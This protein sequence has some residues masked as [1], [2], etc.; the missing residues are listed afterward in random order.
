MAVRIKRI[1]FD[2]ADPYRLAQF[3]SQVTGLSEDPG[4]GNAPDDQAPVLLSPDGSLALLFM[5]VPEPEHLKNRVHLDLVPLMSRRD[6]EVDQLL[7][8]GARM[9]DDQRGPDGGG[10]VVLS[11]PEGNEFCVERSDAERAPLAGQLGCAFDAVADLIGNIRADQWPAPTPCADWTVRQVVNHLIG[12]NRV[13]AALL[14]GEPPPPRPSEDHVEDDPV[15]AYRASAAV[16]QAAFSRPGVLERTY[17]GPLGTAT[18]AERLQIRLYDLL[19]H[20]WDLAQATG[21]PVVLPYDLAE[22]SLVFAQTQL[23]EQARPGRFGP[24]QIVARQAPAI[25]RLVAFLGRPVN[26]DTEPMAD[27]ANQGLVPARLRRGIVVRAR[28]D[29]CEIFRDGRLCTLR[30]ATQFPSPRTERVSPGHLVA[31]ASAPDD[32]EVVVWR[33]YDAVVLGEEAG[34]VRLWEPSHGE[35]LAQPRSMHQSSQPGSRA[36]LSAGLPGADWWVA[37]G[38]A[39][40]AEDADVELDEV[41]QFYTGRELWGILL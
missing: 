5:A 12:M 14:A 39:A 6:E 25:E 19:A 16:L 33:W 37:G 27:S 8:V 7:R 4:N 11:D 23:T 3:W 31:I 15:G 30:Y 28:E 10:W 9:I 34:L 24:A 36:Y 1:T 2:C 20:G 21:Q 29:A 13:F 40:C 17:D 32:T 41:E 26:T 22:Q 38:A 35:V 18:G